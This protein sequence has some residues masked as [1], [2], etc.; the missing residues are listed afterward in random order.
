MVLVNGLKVLLIVL[1]VLLAII[2]L[3]VQ[4]IP[5]SILAHQAIIAHRVLFF[6]LLVHKV[7]IEIRSEEFRL[8]HACL[9]DLVINVKKEPKIL[10]LFAKL[11]LFVQE[12]L[13]QPNSCVLLERTQ[14]EKLV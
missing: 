13:I 7:L 6:Q 4:M 14:V 12:E 5:F 9:V 11:D 10:G 1:H 2:V 3:K 8:H